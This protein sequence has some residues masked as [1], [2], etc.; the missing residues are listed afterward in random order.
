MK[1]GTKQLQSVSRLLVAPTR[2]AEA[3]RRRKH[4]EGRWTFSAPGTDQ[5]RLISTKF[6]LKIKKIPPH[7]RFI[8]VRAPRRSPTE[9]GLRS[10]TCAFFPPHILRVVSTWFREELRVFAAIC[11]EKIKIKPAPAYPARSAPHPRAELVI[12]QVFNA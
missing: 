11:D 5:F 7:L 8:S 6:G 12:A 4:S 10:K 2:L 9:A 1:M 3:L